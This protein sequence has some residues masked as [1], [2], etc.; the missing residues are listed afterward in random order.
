MRVRPSFTHA[1]VVVLALGALTA[2]CPSTDEGTELPQPTKDGGIDTNVNPD[3]GDGTDTNPP[4]E[5][6]VCT[7]GDLGKEACGKCG[8]HVRTCGPEG[9]W[10]PWKPCEDELPDAE[11]SIGETRDA[12]CNMCGKGKDTC[13]T[14]T[15][16]WTAG[17][18]TGTG[19]CNPG[20]P[21]DKTSAS[22]SVPGEVRTRECGTDC[23]WGP[24]S[25]CGLPRGWVKINSPPTGFQPRYLA[26]GVWTGKNVVVWGGYGNY[27]AGP[28]GGFGYTRAD[29]VSYDLG[30]DSWTLITAAPTAFNG[31]RY[32]HTA[33]MNGDKMLVFGGAEN[34]S[35]VN[36]LKA[37]G[38]IYDATAKTWKS[39]TATGAPAARAGHA[40]VWATS[41]SEMLVW[42]GCSSLSSFTYCSGVLSDGSAYDPATDKWNAQPA[43]PPGFS[44]RYKP[45]V[46]WTGDEMIVWGGQTSTSAWAKDGARYDPKTR[47]WTKFSDPS[48]DGR[49]FGTGEWSG[50]ELLVWGGYGTYLG[51]SY[52]RDDGARY[53]P[54]GGWSAM[55]SPGTELSGKR[56]GQTS[57]FGG[58]KLYI[59][60]GG[61]SKT[62]SAGGAAYDPTLD[63]WTAMPT[64]DAPSSR[65]HAAVA[66]TGK[67]AILLGGSNFPSGGTPM[68]DG[69]LFRP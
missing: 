39:M 60:S 5:G 30:S 19:E 32:L 47:V 42:G 55:A 65:A 54:G 68:S 37:D 61:D 49:F 12:T 64:T 38:A 41:T 43:P 1:S 35:F 9:T 7:P 4:K 22:C 2:G 25:A 16:T 28:S 14:T 57:W 27:V 3:T 8:K 45:V 63:K 15:C 51:V 26:T 58:G 50:K 33:V 62:I 18:C 20:D 34:V 52:A 13:D 21:P 59:W 36:T 6:G 17:T 31:G 69:G 66:W 46:V 53:L 24:F 44:G 11:C 48:L 40:A 10:N 67:E 56:W 29:G 23:K